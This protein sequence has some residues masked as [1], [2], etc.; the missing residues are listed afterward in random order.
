VCA[1]I[2]RAAGALLLIVWLAVVMA[3][4]P[5]PSLARKPARPAP[6]E[7]APEPAESPIEEFPPFDDIEPPPIPPIWPD[8]TASDWDPTLENPAEWTPEVPDLPDPWFPEVQT[9][10]E[11]PLQL[12]PL[13]VRRPRA[14]VADLL[15]EPAAILDEIVRWALP[16]PIAF[17]DIVLFDPAAAEDPLEVIFLEELSRHQ[18]DFFAEFDRTE[19]LTIGVETYREDVD[20]GALTSRQRRLLV[21]TVRRA[22]KERYRIPALDLDSALAVATEGGA[23]EVYA[24]P[25]VTSA[26]AF[27]FGLRR[28]I[29]VGD[30]V[31]FGV[32]IE[33]GRR[34]WRVFTDDASHPIATVSL[35]LFR[36][37]VAA[38]CM[39]E[40]D[41][42]RVE[43]S[44]VGLGT[45]LQ[46]AVEAVNGFRP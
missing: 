21:D 41:E 44:F 32:Q 13:F 36:W 14:V 11:E 23:A 43:I 26:Y 38:I 25:I 33:Q 22:Y 8:V 35:R 19:L 15:R 27:Q 4:A 2:S 7:P 24:I 31:V 16:R 3:P 39:I 46:A 40:G 10:R 28:T 37:P 18:G 12:A 1:W 9:E 6:I 5:R 17:G 29:R 30:D 34:V 42:G 20:Q 45:D